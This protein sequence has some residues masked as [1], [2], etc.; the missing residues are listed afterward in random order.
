MH[1]LE[2]IPITTRNRAQRLLW[3]ITW[4]LLYRPSPRILH[5]WRRMLLRLFG[6]RIE[7]GA[8]PHPRTR[9][10]APWN[11][12]MG[13]DSCLGDDVDCYTVARIRLGARATVSQYSYLCTAS[14]DYLDP[15]H[16]TVAAP[17]IIEDDVWVA[18]DVFVG[19]GVTVGAGAVIA[20]RS[21]VIRDVLPWTVVAGSPPRLIRQ[22][23]LGSP[24]TPSPDHA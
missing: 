21:T 15:A 19:P 14:H 8:R 11:L 6:A 2:H 1:P 22:R 16:P 4:T 20:A 5:A 17:I 18:A 23:I 3:E 12:D 24:A 9:I 13:P 7:R 10:W